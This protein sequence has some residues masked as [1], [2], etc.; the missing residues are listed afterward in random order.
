MARIVGVARTRSGAAGTGSPLAPVTVTGVRLPRQRNL[1]R[2]HD[3]ST[4]A[5]AMRSALTIAPVKA[6]LAATLLSASLALAATAAQ[7]ATGKT[8]QAPGQAAADVVVPLTMVNTG[9]L[10]FGQMAQ[11]NASGKITVDTYGNTTTTSG[12]IGNNLIDQAGSGPRAGTFQIVTTPG[13]AFAV[14]GPPSFTIRNGG[15]SMTV[16][17]LTARLLQTGSGATA[18]TYTLY[19]GAT[20]SVRARQAVGS[21]TGSYTLTAVYQ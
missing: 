20:L 21:Y 14:N 18:T 1:H 12:M 16:T 19:V 7:A 13:G 17:L 4:K 2:G 6:R 8:A 5:R 11:P 3:L 15:S 10:S 9:V